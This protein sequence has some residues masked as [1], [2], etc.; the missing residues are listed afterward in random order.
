MGN[1]PKIQ[2]FSKTLHLLLSVLLV[3]IPFIDVL[4]WS[5]INHLPE[6]LI[7]VN[8]RAEP[9]I[10][11]DLSAQWRVAGFLASLFP[12]AALLYGILNLRKLFS[13]YGQGRIFS[14][15]HVSIFRNTAKALLLWVFFS[16]LYEGVKSIL[17]SLG[18]GPGNRVVTL[19]VSSSEVMILVVGSIVWII[20]WV[21]DE[22]RLLNEECELTV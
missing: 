20:A 2:K 15:E 19:G 13:Y 21:M 8:V 9:L 16:I 7:T 22:G 18:A 17:F 1:L 12:L 3:V 11:Y 5:C 14:L 4:Y 10:P 6:R